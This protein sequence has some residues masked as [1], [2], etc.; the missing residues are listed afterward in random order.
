MLT[1]RTG[2]LTHISTRL[3]QFH[4]PVITSTTRTSSVFKAFSSST[5]SS[6]AH[7][8]AKT[9]EADV[10]VIGGGHAGCEAATAAARAG[11]SNVLMKS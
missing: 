2:S 6:N 5:T 4:R 3:R 1:S 8:R 9:Y 11:T 7:S 10:V